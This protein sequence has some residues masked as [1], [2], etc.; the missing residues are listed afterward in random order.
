MP[1]R[2][3]TAPVRFGVRVILTKEEAFGSCQTLADAGRVLVRSGR[4]EE[5]DSLGSLFDLLEE[6]LV[7]H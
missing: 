5:A 7:A 4:A 3:A 1:E 6:R 2:R